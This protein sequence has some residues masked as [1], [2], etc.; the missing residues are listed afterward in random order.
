MTRTSLCQVTKHH[1]HLFLATSRKLGLFKTSQIEII[2]NA[3]TVTIQK[4]I[5]ENQDNNCLIHL[6]DAGKCPDTPKDVWEAAL[7]AIKGESS[8]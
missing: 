2:M 4:K 5:I 7:Q 8:L 3:N 6:S 1:T